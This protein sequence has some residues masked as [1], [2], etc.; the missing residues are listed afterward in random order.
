[1]QTDAEKACLHT[2]EIAKDRRVS[3]GKG[4]N[5]PV[6]QTAVYMVL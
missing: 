4:V 3:S 1:M 2:L 5:C 6:G